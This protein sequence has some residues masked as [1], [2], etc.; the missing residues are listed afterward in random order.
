M[1]ARD[2]PQACSAAGLKSLI[3]PVPST[4]RIGLS[5]ERTT[6]ASAHGKSVSSSQFVVTT[7]PGRPDPIIAPEPPE[8]KKQ[9]KP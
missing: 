1:S 9:L 8:P 6:L 3:V 5:D 4:T 7:P 2:W